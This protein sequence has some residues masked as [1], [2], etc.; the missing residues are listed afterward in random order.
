MHLKRSLL[1]FFLLFSIQYV[2]R[3]QCNTLRPQIDIS[4]NTDQDCA[5]VSVTQFQITYY[6]NAAQDPND[7][8]ILYEWNDPTNAVTLVD[9][10]SGLIASAGNTAFTANATF[11]YTQNAQCTIVPTTSVFI[12]GV[13]CPTSRQTQTAF[14]WDTDDEGNGNV[15]IAPPSW[16]V[17]FDNPIVNAVFTD[18]SEFNCNINVEPDNP[19]QLT[20]HVQFVYGTNHNPGATIRNLTLTDGGPQG[21]TNGT[22]NLVTSSTRGTPGLPVTG[23]YFGP[24]DAIPFPANGPIS[25]SFPMNAPAD[26]LNLV[27]NRF[28]ITLFNWN[29]CNPWNGDPVNPNYEDAIETRAYITIVA[30]PAPN[31]VTRDGGG[32]AT[33]DFCINEV[34]FLDNLTPN[35][36]ALSWTWE[37]YSNPTG[38]GAPVAV[39]TGFEPTFAY[40]VGGQKLIRLRA[41]NPTAQSP[42]VETFEVVVNITPALVANIRVTDLANVDI[43]P[44][45]CQEGSPPLTNFDARF[46]DVSVGTVTANTR[47]RWEF[48][49][50]SNV[51]VA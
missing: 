13:L 43:T 40:G 7:I 46:H 49:N 24:I 15:T 14:F 16:D 26:P 20:R 6:F 19:N 34:I 50:E 39:R 30:A 36:A 5:P 12:G 51:M 23:A 42:C 32:N 21:L 31:F 18:A 45:F 44:D 8:S 22:G 48:Y 9:I 17:C 27:G 33:T 41:S 29:I 10:G 11:T 37:F 35:A 25:V 47:W 3:A 4:F 28:E 2:A 1:V 38:A